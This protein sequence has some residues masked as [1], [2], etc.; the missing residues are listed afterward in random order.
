MLSIR[1]RAISTFKTCSENFDTM[2]E[3]FFENLLFSIVTLLENKRSAV[4][5]ATI[6]FAF[7]LP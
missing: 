5:E 1:R 3:P 6:D 2:P 7:S 4:F